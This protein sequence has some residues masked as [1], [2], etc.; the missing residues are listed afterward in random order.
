MKIIVGLGNIGAEYQRTYHNIGF[1]MLD[2][3]A[4]KHD[5]KFSKTKYRSKVAEMFFE[6]EKVLL[7]KPETYMNASGQAVQNALNSLKLDA[8]NL[9]VVY[10]DID[11]KLGS[12][13][14]RLRGSAGTHNGMRNIIAH[15]GTNEFSRLR[16]GIGKENIRDLTSFVLSKVSAEDRVVFE[17]LHSDVTGQIEDFILNRQ[18]DSE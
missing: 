1:D 16:V 18:R 2:A 13:R 17:N 8:T 9:L 10:D 4:A 14:F 11:L 7:L 6:G 12:T 3:F 5:A 15:I